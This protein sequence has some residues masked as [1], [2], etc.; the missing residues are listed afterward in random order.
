MDFPLGLKSDDIAMRKRIE[1][2]ECR[3]SLFV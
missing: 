2:A 1:C 3:E